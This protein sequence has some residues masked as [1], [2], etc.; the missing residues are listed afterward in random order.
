MD[1]HAEDTMR[2][3]SRT[4]KELLC[5]RAKWQFSHVP[6]LVQDIKT[7]CSLRRAASLLHVP[8]TSFMCICSLPKHGVTKG[9]NVTPKDRDE[10]SK[11]IHRG[12]VSMRL[13]YKRQAKNVYMRSAMLTA[14]KQ[15]TK[16]QSMLGN[17][18]LGLTSF[19]LA[20]PKQLKYMH[21]V[22]FRNCQC[23][24]C[25]NCSLLTD[26]VRA[27]KLQGVPRRTTEL[28][29]R[30]L[31]P[32]SQ[33]TC[34][35]LTVKQENVT[36]GDCHQEC[37]FCQCNLCGFSKYK[38]DLMD[39]NPDFDYT[40]NV[41]WHQWETETNPETGKVSNYSKVRYRDSVFELLDTFEKKVM[42]MSKHLFHFHWQAH[43]FELIRQSL[44]A[45]ELLMVID[46]AQNLE[47]K[48]ADEPQSSHW[49]HKQVTLHPCVVYFLCPNCQGP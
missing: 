41:V 25:L 45:D 39:L 31:C 38:Q 14:Y 44:S 4:H 28:V 8:F 6:K 5:V 23:E 22:P 10:V 35:P 33:T 13:P 48:R 20:L 29:L 37:I 27:S 32:P 21:D 42:M 46:F 30:T 43:Q 47:I 49:H 17:Q 7:K 18:V 3:L 26:A 16:E 15:Y 11:F 36:I 24:D 2:T 12:D 1:H 9:R 40:K 34:D 19:Y